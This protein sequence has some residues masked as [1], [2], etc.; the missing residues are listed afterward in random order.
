MGDD[1]GEGLKRRLHK[2]D[3]R[4]C[5]VAALCLWLSNEA[6]PKSSLL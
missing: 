5:L 2:D 6:L 1:D 4:V 3:C